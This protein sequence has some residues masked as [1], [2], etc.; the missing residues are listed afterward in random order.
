MALMTEPVFVDR[1]AA[2]KAGVGFGWLHVKKLRPGHTC[3]IT[4]KDGRVLK[5]IVWPVSGEIEHGNDEQ[6]MCFFCEKP[7]STVGYEI[8]HF[9]QCREIYKVRRIPGT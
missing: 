7:G 6:E 2:K 5:V 9:N 4:T 1:D 3:Q 8:I